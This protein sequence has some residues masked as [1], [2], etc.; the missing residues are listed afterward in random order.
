MK[1]KSYLSFNGNAEE[2]LNFYAGVF[3]GTISEI[4]RYGDY[5]EMES[6]AEYKD[7]IIHSDLEFNSCTFSMAD[8]MPGTKTDFGSLGHTITLF[9]DSEEQLKD[10]YAKLSAAGQIKCELCQPFYAKLYAEIVDKFGVAWAL[11][12]E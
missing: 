1:I 3:N 8:A 5:P 12:I 11:I 2:A 9:C 7:K 6:P 4:C 10:I